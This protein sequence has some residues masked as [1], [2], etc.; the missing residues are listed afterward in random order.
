[1]SRT[2]ND[3]VLTG[4]GLLVTFSDNAKIQF[5][6]EFINGRLLLSQ[7]G[8]PC[9]ADTIYEIINGVSKCNRGTSLWSHLFGPA[10]SHLAAAA[11]A[12]IGTTLTPNIWTT[13]V[14][15]NIVSESQHTSSSG[16]ADLRIELDGTIVLPP[17]EYHIV[18]RFL[19]HRSGAGGADG[20]V[21]SMQALDMSD[22]TEV[23]YSFNQGTV[24]ALNNAPISLSSSFFLDTNGSDE[25]II[26]I[27]VQAD[28]NRCSLGAE[29]GKVP[30]G[31]TNHAGLL[32][33]FRVG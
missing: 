9:D 8:V 10:N 19:A 6:W 13:L 31:S 21:V 7:N 27:R 18:A 24:P 12:Q 32:T 29:P 16:V 14:Y 5:L 20:I 11:Y 30:T 33:L 23:Q 3:I 28:T 2:V 25:T 1:M 15:D 26:Q 4:Q 22:N 17:G